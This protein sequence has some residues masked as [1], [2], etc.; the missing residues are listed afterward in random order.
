METGS[1]RRHERGARPLGAE[2]GAP[3]P[4]PGGGQQPE[5]KPRTSPGRGERPLR[6][7]LGKQP[8]GRLQ[9]PGA[10]T[11]QLRP[12]DPRLPAPPRPPG[13]RAPAPGGGEGGRRGAPGWGPRVPS[14]L[15]L[16]PSSALRDEP[17]GYSPVAEEGFRGMGPLGVAPP[18]G[19]PPAQ[20]RQSG[21]R[22]SRWEG[23]LGAAAA[24]AAAAA[25]SRRGGW[26]SAGG[27]AA[28]APAP[29]PAPA[30]AARE[31]ATGGA[32]RARRARSQG[33]GCDN[34]T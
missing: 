4:P 19:A 6:R 2:P 1:R 3:P 8:L 33:A 16:S 25:G 10:T 17:P 24:A 14:R 9:S 18:P 34:W 11:D 27:G 12:A 5:R 7:A 21:D 20:D 22:P 26:G 23:A 32:D 30:S 15:P 29:A 28:P 13:T 31:A